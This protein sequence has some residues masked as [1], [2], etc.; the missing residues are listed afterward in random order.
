MSQFCIYSA[1]FMC[2]LDPAQQENNVA[3]VTCRAHELQLTFRHAWNVLTDDGLCCNV[4]EHSC[5][6][7]SR[8]M[9]SRI[10]TYIQ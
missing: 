7:G 10:F 9:L 6:E 5:A 2:I 8:G 4:S 1:G 3:R